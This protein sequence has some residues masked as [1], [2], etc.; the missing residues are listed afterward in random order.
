V[1]QGFNRERL[2]NSRHSFQERV[3][4]TDE[5][6]QH[7][8]GE[9]FL[10]HNYLANLS[11]RVR[12]KFLNIPAHETSFNIEAFPHHLAHPNYSGPFLS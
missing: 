9:L 12:N 7:L 4:A 3:P 10:A 11:P 2:G 8:V 1:R 6:R 5:N